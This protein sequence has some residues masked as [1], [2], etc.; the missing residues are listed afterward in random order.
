MTDLR[1]AL[2]SYLALRRALGFKLHRTEYE[3][4]KFV[5]FV[6]SQPSPFLTAPM[7]LQWA[8]QSSSASPHTWAKLLCIVR[9]FAKYLHGSDARHEVP[10]ADAIPYH[11]NRRHPYIYSD[12]DVAALIRQARSIRF[13]LV[14]ASYA[15]LFGL[16]AVTGMRLG[17]A[18]A[19]DRVDID[20]KTRLLLIRNSKFNKSRQIP[21]HPTSVD[22]L[23]KYDRLR[24]KS[25]PS[26]TVP[27]FL[28]SLAGTRLVEQNVHMTFVRLIR[29]NGLFEK[30]PRPRVHDLRHSF[31]VKTI[32]RWYECGLEVEPRLP[33]LS[34][35][36][37]HVSAS[38]TYWYMTATPELM[39]LAA[40][41]LARSLGKL[42]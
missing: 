26:S 20:W 5:R 40:K 6:R 9:G 29:K 14:A 7:A 8:T 35:F 11:K 4:R 31:A 39:S 30:T 19:L 16:L 36:L 10:P 1:H 25:F 13:P 21:L 33:M 17:E 27:S 15:T 23:H 3:L 32:R 28:V 42:P 2:D 38:S 34:T 22:A 18:L 37:G 12:E 41:R 24:G